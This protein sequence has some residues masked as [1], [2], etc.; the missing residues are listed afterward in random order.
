MDKPCD[1]C[2]ARWYKLTI[3]YCEKSCPAYDSTSYTGQIA[4]LKNENAALREQLEVRVKE[5]C[6]TIEENINLKDLNTR[7][8]AMLEKINGCYTA[9]VAEGLYQVLNDTEDGRLKDL[10]NRRLLW[11]MEGL[12]L[13][14]ADIRKES[15]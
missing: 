1:N 12:G 15:K 13:L 7:M 2:T 10:L 6:R 8:L 3:P 5:Q 14:L 11:E 9:A 4:T